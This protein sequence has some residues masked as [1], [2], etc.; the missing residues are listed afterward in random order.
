MADHYLMPWDTVTEEGHVNVIQDTLNFV[1]NL[2]VPLG[3][4][5]EFTSQRASD[6]AGSQTALSSPSWQPV[7]VGK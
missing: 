1:L 3:C 6:S 7:R 5:E 4:T 2:P